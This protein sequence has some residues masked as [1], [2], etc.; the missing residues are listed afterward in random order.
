MTHNNKLDDLKGRNELGPMSYIRERLGSL[1]DINL[2]DLDIQHI[3]IYI[4]QSI[5]LVSSR[6]SL[7]VLTQEFTSISSFL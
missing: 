2:N 7:F 3:Y 6:S 1:G 5:I 4:C